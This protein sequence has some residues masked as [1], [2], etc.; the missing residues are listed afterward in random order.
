MAVRHCRVLAYLLQVI[1]SAAIIVVLLRDAQV[2]AVVRS[3]R[4]ASLGWLLLAF[5][6][7]LACY[8]MH[9]IRVWYALLPWGRPRF[10]NILG[11]GYLAGLVNMVLPVRAGDMVAVGLLVKEERVPLGTSLATV[12]LVGLLEAAVFGIFLLGLLLLVVARGEAFWGLVQT[13][14]ALGV[15]STFTLVGIAATVVAVVVGRRLKKPVDA[16]ESRPMAE[17]RN[18]LRHTGDTLGQARYL[19]INLSLAVLHLAVTVSAMGFL[20]PAAGLDV[21][22]PVL[23]AAGILGGGA[24]AA[25]VLPPGLGAGPAAA[26]IFVLHFFGASEAEALALAALGWGVANLSAALL[27]LPQLWPRLGALG[28]LAWR[29][30][31]ER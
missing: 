28:T 15:V 11:I 3:L 22:N 31:Y 6:A 9:E 24:L 21:A 1:A 18:L 7:K 26:A 30:P 12:A 29:W 14:S 27:G 10:W 5:L 13:R 16:Q 23:A 8:T 17:L 19:A 20:I 2:D 4:Q 25:V